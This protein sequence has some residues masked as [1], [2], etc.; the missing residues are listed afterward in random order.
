[1]AS[2]EQLKWIR[3]LRGKRMINSMQKRDQRASRSYVNR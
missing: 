3:Q 1:M 2:A